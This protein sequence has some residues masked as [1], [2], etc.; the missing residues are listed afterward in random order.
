MG[1]PSDSFIAGISNDSIRDFLASKTER[2]PDDQGLL[3]HV[4]TQVGGQTNKKQK[5]TRKTRKKEERKKPKFN[6]PKKEEGEEGE[7]EAKIVIEKVSNDKRTYERK[8]MN[9]IFIDFIVEYDC[10]LFP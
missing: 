4:Q 6:P 3:A 10:L 2:S 9:D 7:G 8:K 5:K 1:K